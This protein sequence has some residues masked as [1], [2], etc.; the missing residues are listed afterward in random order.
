MNFSASL[1]TRLAHPFAHLAKGW[2]LVRGASALLGMSLALCAAHAQSA[3]CGLTSIQDSTPPNY[4]PIARAASVSG[5]VVLLATFD[6]T[7][8]VASVKPVSG[9]PMLQG[10]AIDYVKHWQANSSTG[11]RECPVAVTFRM[12]GVQAECGSKDDHSNISLDSFQRLDLQH[13]VITRG[14]SCF[15]TMADPIGTVIP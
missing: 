1:Q 15:V 11:P 13:V 4:P 14:V 10:A 12:V 3:N 5:T 7:G 8:K 6:L 9:H 2:G